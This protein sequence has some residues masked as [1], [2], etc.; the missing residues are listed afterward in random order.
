[1]ECCGDCCEGNIA[2]GFF[3]MIRN[4]DLFGHKIRLQFN[5]RGNKHNTCFGGLCSIL[6]IGFII[7]WL[8]MVILYMTSLNLVY[9]NNFSEYKS[10]TDTK[11]IDLA[12][13][14]M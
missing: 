7:F 3:N 4:Q 2:A 5:K 13:A 9:S 14:K 10:F 12:D 11:S 8:V 6:F 1:M